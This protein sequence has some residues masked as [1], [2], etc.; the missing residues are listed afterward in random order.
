M[1]HLKQKLAL[2]LAVVLCLSLTA[3]G[4]SVVEPDEPDDPVYPVEPVD[5][6]GRGD[7]WR[8]SGDVVASGTITHDGSSVDVLVTVDENHAAFYW[9]QPEQ[10]LFD[11]VSFPVTVSDAQE[12]FSDISF[13]DLDGDGESDVSVG[14]VYAPGD[15]ISMIWI[16]DP[17][18]RYVFR[19]DL[20]VLTTNSG[21]VS[22]Y[23]GLW[24]Y[25]DANLW[26]RIYED[27]TWEFLDDQEDVIAYGTLWVDKEGVMLC[28][29]DADETLWLDRTVSGDLLDNEN[30]GMFVPATSIESRVPY[31]TRYGLEIN[32]EVDAGIYWMDKGVCSFA[33]GDQ[34]HS[35][36]DNYYLGD[37]YWEV[38]KYC[39]ETKGGVRE[40]QFDAICYIPYSSIDDF[41]GA[42]K[43]NAYHQ[44]YD[45][46]TGK[47][48][49]RIDEYKNSKRGKDYYLHTVD[50]NGQSGIIEF[51]R[52]TNWQSD[53]GEWARVMTINYHV[54]MPDWYDGLVLATEPLPDNYKDYEKFDTR[55]RQYAEASIMDIDLVDPYG[56]LFFDVCD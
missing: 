31:F 18:E 28:Y 8:D 47:W 50:W 1:K 49:T 19:E 53:V 54:Y 26:L 38:I 15:S 2:L 37:C 5:V 13:D 44:L 9:D 7:D 22:D 39:D 56:C 46:Y 21:S 41:G 30:N 23:V 17:V 29:E 14:F 35:L 45:S 34:F 20:S 48:F 27:E 52:S 16:W 33:T 6:E 40:L 25:V 43:C 10:I 55:H 32:A 24:E 36:G 12:Y 3:C 42:I 11:T 51:T 4:G